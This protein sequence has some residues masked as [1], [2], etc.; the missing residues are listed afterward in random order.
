MAF[1][2]DNVAQTSASGGL[3]YAPVWQEVLWYVA[4]ATSHNLS[5]CY[6]KDATVN[7][8]LDAGFLDAFIYL[9][10]PAASNSSE[11]ISKNKLMKDKNSFNLITGEKTSEPGAG[12][13]NDPLKTK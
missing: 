12:I 10:A 2:V 7:F 3:S 11:I 9:Y 5:W 8:G 6:L 13:S 1:Y 4:G